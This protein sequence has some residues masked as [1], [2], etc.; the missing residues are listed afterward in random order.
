MM[1]FYMQL[2]HRLNSLNACSR[3]Y[4]YFGRTTAKR[5]IRVYEKIVHPLIYMKIF[6]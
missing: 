5:L 2:Q 3:L 6:P 4:K 1:P